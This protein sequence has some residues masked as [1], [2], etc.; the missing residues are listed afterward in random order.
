MKTAQKEKRIGRMAMATLDRN[1]TEELD[2]ADAVD[3]EM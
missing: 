3:V 2:P 1:E